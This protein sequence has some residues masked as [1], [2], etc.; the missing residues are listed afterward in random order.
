MLSWLGKLARDQRG[1]SAIEFA[2]FMPVLLLMLVGLMELGRA[3]YQAAAMEK[4]LRAGAVFAARNS[5]P[6]AANVETAVENVVKTGNL[7]GAQPYIVPGWAEASAS[8]SITPRTYDVA[9][10][11]LQMV[12]LNATVPYMPLVPGLAMVWG[13]NNYTMSFSHD[14][15]FIGD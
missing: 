9:G 13:L 12:R 2:F 4:A 1:V 15:A 6:L 10:S 3:H 7:Q 11:T 8:F 14:Q 5:M